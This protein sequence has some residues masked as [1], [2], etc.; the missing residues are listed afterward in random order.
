MKP[1]YTE[2]QFDTLLREKLFGEFGVKLEE[3]SNQQIYRALAL[4]VRQRLSD[5][6]K[7][8]MARTYGNNSKQV[9]YLCM[10][11]LM[12]RSLKTNLFNLGWNV[13]AAAALKLRDAG[14]DYLGGCCGTTPEFISALKAALEA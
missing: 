10:E 2:Q 14:A 13:P 7:R 1:T 5:D 11:F 3:A 4:L 12:G 6:R 8:F 9:Y